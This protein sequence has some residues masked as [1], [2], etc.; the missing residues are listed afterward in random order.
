MQIE[1][2]R[3]RNCPLFFMV[4]NSLSTHIN[5]FLETY[6]E[7]TDLFLADIK[8]SGANKVQVYVDRM[9]SNI[10]IDT[11]A[12]ISRYLEAQLE[13]NGLVGEKYTIEVSS[14]G[15]G[16]P[17]KVPQQFTKNVGKHI[18]VLTNEHN[19]LQGLLKEVDEKSITVE[20]HKKV[21]KKVQPEIE[22]V[23]LSFEEIKSVKKEVT[24]K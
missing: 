11:C 6:F 16:N 18:K 2:V 8:I 20:L 15:M 13:E 10:T 12:K 14:P 22:T 9:S 23:K 4:M 5:G 3:G 19:T 1:S 24:F 21:K 17:F 7:S